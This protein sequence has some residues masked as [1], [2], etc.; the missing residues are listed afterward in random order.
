MTYNPEIHHRRSVRLKDYDYSQ[1]GV[2]FVTICTH[3]RSRLFGNIAAD[4]EMRCNA[5]GEIVYQEWGR[6]QELRQNVEL[7]AFVVMPNH[8]HGIVVIWAEDDG[9]TGRTDSQ[10]ATW[11]RRASPLQRPAGVLPDSLGA[12]VGGYKSA[13]TREIN[14]R[15]DTP[16][17]SVWQ[18]SY[19]DVIVRN[20]AMLNELRQYVI[21]NPA[22]WAED[23]YYDS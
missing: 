21:S 19:H 23:R 4:G 2:Y 14:R 8:V 22:Q 15:R 3:D 10:R 16:G 7:D 5:Y 20:E 18:R 9:Q 6:L 12:I 13:V 17:A 1:T 11:A